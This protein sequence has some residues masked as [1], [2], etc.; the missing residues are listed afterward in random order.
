MRKKSAVLLLFLICYRFVSIAQNDPEFPKGYIMHLKIHNGAVTGFNRYP[1]LYVGGLQMVPQVTVVPGLL[2]AGAVA[3]A[4]YGD[5][6]V[7]GL[8]GPTVSVKLKTI[9]AGIFGSAGNIHL[10]LDHLWGT[11]RQRLI[12]G[13]LHADILNR[14]V[15]GITAHR[16]YN[17]NTWWIQQATGIRIS[18]KHIPVPPFNQ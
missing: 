14:V 10:S 16:D 2:R 7:Q 13:G 12:G 17:L 8:F 1:D 11:D 6:K 9:P 3:G 5:K 4:F 18:K 15:V